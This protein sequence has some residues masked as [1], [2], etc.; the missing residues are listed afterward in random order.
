MSV[1]YIVELSNKFIALFPAS[2]A[3][4]FFQCVKNAGQGMKLTICLKK[5]MW[6]KKESGDL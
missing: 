1:Q 4:Y 6:F 3:Q 2:T 5:I